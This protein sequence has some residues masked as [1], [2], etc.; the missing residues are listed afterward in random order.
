MYYQYFGLDG[1][2]FSITP[3]PKF[4]YFSERHQ[5]ALAH[6]L[7]G[8]GRGGGGGFVQLTGEVGTGKTTLCRLLLE[9]VPE[10][11]HP[12]LILNPVLGPRELV[13]TICEELGI[14]YPR[15]AT[16]KAL[17]DLLNRR[18]L[19]IHAAGGR[20]VL[21]VDEA[22][23][24]SPQALEQIRLLTNLE[25]ESAKLLQIVLIGQP[26][27]RRIL[28]QQGL[29][30][31]A[32]RIT[33]R[34]HLMPLA[35]HETAAYVW[36]RL[37]V[38]GAARN[39]FTP[40]GMAEVH[41]RAGGIPRLINIIAD[42]ALLAAY[43]DNRERAGVRTV[44]RAAAE[45]MGRERRP[46][47]RAPAW[48]A[49][50]VLL[51]LAAS[52]VGVYGVGG[53]R[54]FPWGS[55]TALAELPETNGWAAAAKHWNARWPDGSGAGC[56]VARDIGLACLRARGTWRDLEPLA[57]PVVLALGG[58]AGERSWL[59]ARRV[60]AGELEPL[61]GPPAL[62][63]ELVE[64]SWTGEYALLVRLPEFLPATLE[65]GD[66]GKAVAWLRR[67]AAAMDPE[68]D[69]GGD[70]YSDALGSWVAGFQT[71]NGLPATGTADAATLVLIA[72]HGGMDDG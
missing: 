31:I 21:V 33:A 60:K 69:Q 38:A 41:R 23:N 57:V 47:S 17:L 44:R 34:Y 26:E 50:A 65:P 37:A 72:A 5:E 61:G 63:R 35:A 20:A 19:D 8:V 66:K 53:D 25:T 16:R 12:A 3:D 55:S 39:P 46:G 11:V 32:Q 54:F 28:D 30:Q 27:L 4:V 18:L 49:A 14:D 68:V 7:Y 2:P 59:A 29:R 71:R 36:H 62:A 24:L 51:V 15:R 10:T 56:T 22:Q 58:E 52:L 1:P 6:L 70:D 45:V 67:H 9:E 43:T 13:A 48:G 40:R 42:R 64:A